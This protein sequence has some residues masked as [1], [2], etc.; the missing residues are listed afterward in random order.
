MSLCQSVG[1]SG[2]QT[3][4]VIVVIK[5]VAIIFKWLNLQTIDQ[6]PVKSKPAGRIFDRERVCASTRAPPSV[7][8][9]VCHDVIRGLRQLTVMRLHAACKEH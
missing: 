2:V 6:L 9:Y 8:Q 3:T 5:P 1:L 4:V 7:R